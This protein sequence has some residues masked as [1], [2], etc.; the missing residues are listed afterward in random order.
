M[1][2]L[3]PFWCGNAIPHAIAPGGGSEHYRNGCPAGVSRPD[4]QT[5]SDTFRSLGHDRK[6][7]ASV[8]AV[9]GESLPVVRDLD[10]RVRRVDGARDPQVGRAGVLTGVGD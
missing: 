4:L 8:R 7:V 3:L 5:A 6:A 10:L 9:V 1:L 2:G